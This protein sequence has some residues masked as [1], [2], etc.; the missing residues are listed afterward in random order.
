MLTLLALL[1]AQAQAGFFLDADGSPCAALADAADPVAYVDEWGRLYDVEIDKYGAVD[2]AD[3]GVRASAL[4]CHYEAKL[5]VE[6][7]DGVLW[8]ASADGVDPLGKSF[9]APLTTLEEFEVRLPKS[10]VHDTTPPNVIIH[11]GVFSVGADGQSG[12]VILPPPEDLVDGDGS[13]YV[14]LPGVFFLDGL[15]PM[16]AS[17]YAKRVAELQADGVF[18]DDLTLMGLAGDYVNE[19]GMAFGYDPKTDVYAYI[20]HGS[21]TSWLPQF[22]DWGVHDKYGVWLAGDDGSVY[23]LGEDGL[24]RD[25]NDLLYV[26]LDAGR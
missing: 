5:V 15:P 10:G 22:V 14:M 1:T 6:D 21:T 3:L 4:A 23:L 7:D 24:A 20:G 19:F 13:D 12:T 2:L 26:E 11:E 25:L 16:D 17:A 18:L 9:G 8:A